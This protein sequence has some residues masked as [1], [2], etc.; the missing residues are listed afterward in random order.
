MH[1]GAEHN[2]LWGEVDK[3]D[4]ELFWCNG[5]QKLPT[6]VAINGTTDEPFLLV[7]LADG[8]PNLNAIPLNRTGRAI[9]TRLIYCMYSA[10][11]YEQCDTGKRSK[12]LSTYEK[13]MKKYGQS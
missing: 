4:G 10:D 3:V 11:I 9:F 12:E 2:I 13:I 1:A 8:V 6:E 5:G 7:S